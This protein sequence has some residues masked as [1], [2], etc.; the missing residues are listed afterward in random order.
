M[1]GHAL[2]EW[3]EN[4]RNGLSLKENEYCQISVGPHSKNLQQQFIWNIPPTSFK[5]E[6]QA[7][8]K[9]SL[10]VFKLSSLM[11]FTPI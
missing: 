2:S 11:K 10:S 7:W 3:D 8:G 5:A 4:S 9:H 6:I 1:L